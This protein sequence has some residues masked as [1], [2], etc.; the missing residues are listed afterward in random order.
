ME[1]RGE[2]R[3]VTGRYASLNA[4]G[5]GRREALPVPLPIPVSHLDAAVHM[6]GL[7]RLD[8]PTVKLHT[9]VLNNTDF[10]WPFIRQHVVSCPNGRL[11]RIRGTSSQTASPSDTTSQLRSA[12]GASTAKNWTER[13]WNDLVQDSVEVA[14]I[15]E[16]F[17]HKGTN[18]L[19]GVRR[20]PAKSNSI[21][22][23]FWIYWTKAPICTKHI[24]ESGA[25]TFISYKNECSRNFV[26]VGL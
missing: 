6:H 17:L 15:S 19:Q 5:R 1:S 20:F 18:S 10:E 4:A 24:F 2:A 3:G 16:G 25:W 23:V 14:R 7:N 11:R 26:F 22:L 12:A 8:G 13:P 21:S 9:G